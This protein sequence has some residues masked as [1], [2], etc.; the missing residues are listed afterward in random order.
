M[1]NSPFEREFLDREIQ[2][3][4]ILQRDLFTKNTVRLAHPS[5]TSSTWQK[6]CEYRTTCCSFA[7]YKMKD[8][9]G[10]RSNAVDLSTLTMI[11]KTHKK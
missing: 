8:N 3:N 1:K 2:T 9:F 4:T 11:S 7:Y 5:L 6:N 10:M